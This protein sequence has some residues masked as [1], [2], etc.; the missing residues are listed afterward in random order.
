MTEHRTRQHLETEEL[1]RVALGEGALPAAR[2]EHLD[3][4][5]RCR[6]ELSSL[7]ALHQKLST[8][9]HHAPS[10]GFADAVV[11]RVPHLSAPWYVRVLSGDW[12]PW[13]GF[14]AG[15]VALSAIGFWIWL[16]TSSGVAIQPVLAVA[17][18]W[19]HTALWDAVVGA[20]QLLYDSGLG[21]AV[22]ELAGAMTPGTAAA[23][24]AALAVLGSLASVTVFKLM[25][26]PVPALG[27]ARRT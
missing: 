2:R 18:E 13:A 6:D 22:A 26:L 25:E 20:G 11:S 14:S 23:L 21:P 10:P 16:F 12:A 5:A 15:A 8:L 7:E 19:A 9:P 4:C 3:G 17:L 27:S 24:L 1:E